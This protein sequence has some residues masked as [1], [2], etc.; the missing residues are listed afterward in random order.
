MR[1]SRSEFFHVHVTRRSHDSTD[2]LVH[3]CAPGAIRTRDTRFRRAVLYPLSYEGNAPD[4]RSNQGSERHRQPNTRA[5]NARR[6]SRDH[7]LRQTACPLRRT[8]PGSL[9]AIPGTPLVL[10][11]EHDGSDDLTPRLS[12]APTWWPDLAPC[13]CARRARPSQG[14]SNAPAPSV[15]SSP[16]VPRRTLHALGCRRRSD[17]PPS[18]TR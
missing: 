2:T 18:R 6:R 9:N 13:P 11:L 1:R 17:R 3:C 8:C 10:V 14:T 16:A 5:V 7:P 15:T 12:D 4:P